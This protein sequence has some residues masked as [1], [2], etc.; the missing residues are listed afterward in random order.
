MALRRGRGERTVGMP[1]ADQSGGKRGLLVS[2]TWLQVAALVILVGFF[3][4]VLLA[5]RTYQSDPPIPDKVVDPGGR[6][7]FTGNDIRAGQKVFLHHGLMEY[8]SIFGHGAYLGPDFTDDYLH[9]SSAI[10][11]GQ[12]GRQRLGLGE[13]GDDRPVPDEP[14]R[15]GHED[16]PLL[17]PAGERLRP[18][19]AALLRLPRQRHDEIRA[20]AEPHQGPDRDP[21]ADRVLRLVLLGRLGPP[22]RAQLLVHE[23]LAAGAAGR[24]HAQRERDRLVGDLAD[25]AARRDRQCCSRPSGAGDSAGRAATRRR[26]VSARRATW[27]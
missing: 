11:Q 27:R 10:V 20:A 18:A 8:G 19:E 4:L 7:L 2:R 6:V 23:Q 5:Y 22:A 13:A 21:P 9:R 26:S 25:R 12:L 24:Q 16:A 14:V 17:R 1:T 15:L 3:V